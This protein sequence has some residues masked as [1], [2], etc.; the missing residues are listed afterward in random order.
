MKHLISFSCLWLLFLPLSCAQSETALPLE[1]RTLNDSLTNVYAP[2]KRVSLF[3]IRYSVNQKFITLQGVTTSADAHQALLQGLSR[4]NYE[5]TDE[6]K[7]LPDRETLGDQTWGVVR[8]S[9]CNLR[10]AGDYDAGQSSQALLGMPVRV[11]R[12]DDWLQV[13]TPDNYIAWVLPSCVQRVSKAELDAWNRGPQVVVT[14]IFG[15]VYSRPDDASQTVSDVVAGDRLKML[16]EAGKYYSVAY[17]DGRRGYISRSV[18]QPLGSWRSSLHQDVASILATAK[19]LMGIPYMWGGTSTKGVDCSG[20]VRTTLFMHD[21]IIPRDASQQA[22]KGQHI[23]IAPDFSNV[24]PGDLLFFGIREGQRVQHVAIYLGNKRFIH[25]LG[26]VHISS[27][28]PSDADYDAY[29]L[30]RLL[31]A[32][33]ILPFIN[34]EDGLTTTD[35]NA[36]YHE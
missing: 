4:L 19:T 13:Q 7:E 32:A 15:F 3:D 29:D 21:I 30:H 2:D 9:A 27:F 16:G 25:S 26:F 17:P 11:L 24:Q 5:V 22:L 8:V 33:R 28:D 6:I 35:R 34:K 23:D 12:K 20:F 36:Y 1:V 31:F 18:A 10:V 14:A